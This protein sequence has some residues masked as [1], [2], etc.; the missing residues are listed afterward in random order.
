[1]TSWCVTRFP[2]L[3]FST[4]T[5]SILQEDMLMPAVF[6]EYPDTSSSAI[7]F[8]SRPSNTNGSSIS[9]Q[10]DVDATV[11][12][13]VADFNISSNPPNPKMSFRVGDWM[14]VTDTHVFLPAFCSCSL[15]TA[16]FPQIVLPITSGTYGCSFRAS[17]QPRNWWNLLI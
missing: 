13:F 10:F 7:T 4:D 14:Y 17:L 6:S 12:N 3:R 2:G 8:S 9:C 5:T 16:A 15:F 1:M 11:T